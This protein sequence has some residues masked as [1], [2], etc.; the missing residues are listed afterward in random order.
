MTNSAIDYNTPASTPRRIS[1][2]ALCSLIFGI[3]GCIPFVAGGVALLLGFAGFIIA[4][5][6]NMKG[7]WMAVLGILFGLIS[8]SAW[9]VVAGSGVAIFSFGKS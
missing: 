6:P 8:I 5:R 2:A 4:G 3:L 7:R 1:K 9:T